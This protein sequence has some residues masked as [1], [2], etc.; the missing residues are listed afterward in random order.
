MR[1]ISLRYLNGM[2]LF[3]VYGFDSLTRLMCMEKNSYCSDCEALLIM[4][5]PQ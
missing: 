3:I 5:P 1:V 2:L 4:V